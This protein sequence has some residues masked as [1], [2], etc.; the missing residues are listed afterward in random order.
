MVYQNANDDVIIV[1]AK[2]GSSPLGK[3]KI[4]DEYYQQGTTKY[5]QSITEQ[6]ADSKKES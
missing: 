4:G 3:M 1:E 2:G 5:A 6:M